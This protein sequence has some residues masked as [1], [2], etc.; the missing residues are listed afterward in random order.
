MNNKSSI[1]SVHL[2]VWFM[3]YQFWNILVLYF[4]ILIKHQTD[5]NVG[6]GNRTGTPLHQAIKARNTEVR[7]LLSIS[8][9]LLQSSGCKS[10]NLA[11]HHQFN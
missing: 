6:Q 11:K 4:Q 9:Y 2:F 8:N 10:S 5:V 1:C 3:L 7:Q